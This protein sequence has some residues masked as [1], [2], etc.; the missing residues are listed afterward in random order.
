MSAPIDMEFIRLISDGDVEFE[1][2]LLETFIED[3]KVH[4][5][6]AKVAIAASDYMTVQ[7]EAHHMKG[8][9]GNVG[10]HTMQEL[11]SAIEQQAKQE[12]LQDVAPKLADI[13]TNLAEVEAFTRNYAQQQV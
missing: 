7:R 5:D 2:E 9:S 12:S 3:T 6:A 10:A 11:A 1:L 4:I 8:A 13:E